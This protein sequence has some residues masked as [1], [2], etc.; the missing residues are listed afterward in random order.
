M[1][2]TQQQASGLTTVVLI[3]G[4]RM[5]TLIAQALEADGGFEVLGTY[6]INNADE[7]DEAAP[8][9]AL[10]IDF[11]NKAAL[12]HVLA[13]IKRTGAALVSGTTGFNE[14]EQ[15]QMRSLGEVAPVIWSGNYSL[16]VAA[17]RHATELVARAVPNW[18]AEIVETHHNQKADAPSGTAEMLRACIDPSG[19]MHVAHG[20]QGMVGV[21]PQ[22]EIGMHALR[23]GTVA[24]THEVHFFG[25]DE[26]LCLTHRATS[27]Q[28]FVNGAVAAAKK[29]LTCDKGFYTFDQ[30]MFG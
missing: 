27:R 22:R 5:G 14:A 18:D 10:A 19:E 13:Y 11:S 28:I 21:R 20:R 12:P 29:L 8:A 2:S 3:G 24:G 4:G 6:D 26:E 23:G 9:A 7:L 30:L 16:G 17:L 1:T 15:A 25:P